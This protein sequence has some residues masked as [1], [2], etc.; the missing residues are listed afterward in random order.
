M[1]QNNERAK[2]T[3]KAKSSKQYSAENFFQFQPVHEPEEDKKEKR[4]RRRQER[5]MENER[6]QR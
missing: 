1:E 6:M 3:G 4:R 2:D 5:K